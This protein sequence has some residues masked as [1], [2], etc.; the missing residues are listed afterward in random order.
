MSKRAP[1]PAVSKPVLKLA[2]FAAVASIVAA[3]C[4]GSSNSEGAY[5]GSEASGSEAAATTS[6]RYGGGSAGATNASAETGQA[7]TVSVAS[8]P[9][10][11]RVLVDSEGSTLYEF[12][13]DK[14]GSSSCYGACAKNWPPL[15]TKGSPTPSNGASAAKLG[16]TKRS[17]GTVQ[18]TYADRPLYT[19]VS[20]AKPGDAK[21]NNF[22]AFGAEWY[23]LTP[24]GSHP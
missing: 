23:A 1:K 16:T 2:A 7:A 11:G 5:G 14:G 4:G 9:K 20:D 3:G 6:G 15:L 24:Q 8:V 19:F 13:K 21:G 12:E 17:D 22:D 10:L 18:V